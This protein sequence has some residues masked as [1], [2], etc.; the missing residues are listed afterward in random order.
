MQP[1]PREEVIIL[2]D[3]VFHEPAARRE[4]WTV[5]VVDDDDEVHRATELCLDALVIDDRP[6]QLVYAHSGRE[7]YEYL[8]H[9]PDVAVILLDVVME[10]ASAGLDLVRQVRTELELAKPRIILRT[11]Q[12]GYAPELDVIRAYDINDYRVKAELTQTRL[13][14]SLTAAVRAY[15]QLCTLDCALQR[16]TLMVQEHKRL[17]DARNSET[18][19]E[20]VLGLIQQFS[21]G[22]CDGLFIFHKAGELP[23]VSWPIMGWM[24]RF[25]ESRPHSIVEIEDQKIADHLIEKVRL[26][27]TIF[28]GRSAV[29]CMTT[30]HA[31]AY[32]YLECE[33]PFTL[34]DEKLIEV[35][36][37]NVAVAMKNA[38][39]FEQV[40]WQAYNDAVLCI[41]NRSRFIELMDAACKAG[42]IDGMVALVDIDHFASVNDALGH[43]NGDELLRSI[44]RR[45]REHIPASVVMARVSSDVIGL[46]STDSAIDMDMVLSVFEQ[47]FSILEYQLPVRVTCGTAQLE[48]AGRTGLDVLK[49]CNLALKQAKA[50]QRGAACAFTVEMEH[51]SRSRT[52]LL[53]DLRAALDDNLLSLYYQPQVDAQDGELIGVE[54]LAR[55]PLGMDRYI[56][57][58]DFIPVAEASGLIVP[59]GKWALYRA[60]QQWVEWQKMGMPKIRMAVNVSLPQFRDSDFVSTVLRIIDETG[61][62]PQWLEL[63]LTES[64]AMSDRLSTIGCMNRLRNSGISFAIDDFG[65]GFSSL[66][67]L[68]DLPMDRL[69]IDRVFVSQIGI[70]EREKIGQM[71]VSLAQTLNIDSIAEG[72]ETQDQLAV[73]RSWG[74][75][76][77]QGFLFARP[78]PP[79]KLVAWVEKRVP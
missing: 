42:D 27:S 67:Y 1:Q 17:L 45:L 79:E 5:L 40:E 71:V 57:P 52:K 23:S 59:L 53:H 51:Q 9:H 18:L 48:I 29:I 44:I 66:C 70:D 50:V 55:W 21:P 58:I 15:G 26:R 11:G 46:L 63:E 3:D 56:P 33:Q 38:E 65:T 60:C 19:A 25:A 31:E 39:L 12:P 77:A 32:L 72:V 61:M 47:P 75:R 35:F 73:L 20:N 74:C 16:L 68:Q 64:T 36:S 34:L 49:N 4:P 62:D 28:E 30:D 13:V 24:G 6:L 14:T 78:L 76:E 7:A 8:Q 41:P 54:A 37:V 10:T 2:V 22:V 69:K 43:Q